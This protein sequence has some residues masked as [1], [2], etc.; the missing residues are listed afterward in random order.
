MKMTLRSYLSIFFVLAIFVACEEDDTIEETLPPEDAFLYSFKD[1][2]TSNEVDVN[3]NEFLSSVTITV[4]PDISEA[5]PEG[6]SSQVVIQITRIDEN[7]ETE[8][9]RG[10]AFSLSGNGAGDA[11]PFDLDFDEI[12][13]EKTEVNITANLLESGTDRK[14]GGAGILINA[15]PDLNDNTIDYKVKSIVWSDTIDRNGDGYFASRGFTFTIATEGNISKNLEGTVSIISPTTGDTSLLA[16]VG[17]IEVKREGFSENSTDILINT[18]D[19]LTR[20]AYEILMRFTEVGGTELVFEQLYKAADLVRIG[21]EPDV[22]DR[23][24]YSLVKAPTLGFSSFDAN[25]YIED[26]SFSFEVQ[27]NVDLEYGSGDF[28]LELPLIEISY[29]RPFSNNYDPDEYIELETY[30]LTADPFNIQ[31]V[32]ADITDALPGDSATYYFKFTILEPSDNSF[33]STD[34]LIIAEYDTAF[35]A[36]LGGIRINP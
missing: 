30:Q 27:A 5:A 10:P 6:F 31:S 22:Y 17:P 3:G 25:G 34:D 24:E 15:E 18:D 33:S 36:S 23:R 12:I 7:G 13:D 1:I 26:P 4:D 2:T 29:N 35:D 11:Q 32:M 20:G 16:N 14:L 21:F 9:R 28:E 8:I 19:A